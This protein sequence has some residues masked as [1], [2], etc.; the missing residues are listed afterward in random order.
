MFCEK[1]YQYPNIMWLLLTR[2]HLCWSLFLILSIAK[3]FRALILQTAASENVFIKIFHKE[4]YFNIKKPD[5]FNI[6]NKWF[7]M[8][9]V[10]IHIIVIRT[11]SLETRAEP[12]VL[13]TYVENQAILE[14]ILLYRASKCRQTKEQG[15]EDCLWT[16]I[17][18]FL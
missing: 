5:F 2:K 3:F 12:A 13:R 17:F 8:K 14:P 4:N 7:P 18:T 15:S 16:H 10:F 1:I 6:R 9:L 11:Y